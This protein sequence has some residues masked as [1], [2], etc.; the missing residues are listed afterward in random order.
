[1]SVGARN[2]FA[3]K[4]EFCLLN[5]VTGRTIAFKGSSGRILN[6]GIWLEIRRF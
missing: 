4:L 5:I 6:I 1:M 2:S 3:G